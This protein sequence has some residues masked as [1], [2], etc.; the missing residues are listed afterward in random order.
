MQLHVCH[1]DWILGSSYY[2]VGSSS[3]LFP[4]QPKSMFSCLVLWKSVEVSS[5]VAVPFFIPTS[6]EWEV[7]LLHILTS[8]GCLHWFGFSHSNRCGCYSFLLILCFSSGIT[9]KPHP[10]PH[11]FC[12]DFLD[13]APIAQTLQVPKW[14][15]L[16]FSRSYL[17]PFHILCSSQTPGIN[18]H[19]TDTPK[20]L[21]N[22]CTFLRHY[23]LR[24]PL[25]YMVLGCDLPM[26]STQTKGSACSL[27]FTG[28]LTHPKDYVSFVT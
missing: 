7:L 23:F 20:P 4:P 19:C 13:A 16:F 15:D 22:F 2:M 27:V 9:F 5:K 26:T 10:K 21:E 3:L 8:T 6:R 14:S 1:F 17:S 12:E 25:L 28:K 18:F 24:V 11:L